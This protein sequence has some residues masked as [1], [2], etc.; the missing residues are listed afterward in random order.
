[1][2][3]ALP[4][5]SIYEKVLRFIQLPDPSAF[6]PL[7]IEVFRYQFENVPPYRTYCLDRGMDPGTVRTV[8]QIPAVSTV[9]FKYARME[10]VIEPP[11]G[12]SRLFLTSGTTIG[13]D[14]RGRH[15]VPFPEIYRASAIR[16]LN[17]MLFPDA[18]RTAMLALHPTADRMPESSLSQ[19]I[20]WC[21][22]EFGSGAAMCAATPSS[23]DTAAAIEFLRERAAADT[24]V[25]ILGTTASI[26]AL[27]RA[28]AA[29]GLAIELPAASRLMDTGGPKGQK[30]PLG[31]AEVAELAQRKLGLAPAMVINEYGMTEMCSQLYDATSFNSAH[32]GAAGSRVKLAPPWLR[33][34]ALDPVTLSPVFSGEIGLLGFF[35]LANVGSVSA[36]ITED[37]GVVS[38]DG[39]A[40]VG[41]AAGDSRGCA[42]AIEEFAARERTG[43]GQRPAA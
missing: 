3:Q 38:G 33:A 22:E 2:A 40:I 34:V 8:A 32:N 36:L 10:S 39:V 12:T 27:F 17:K 29:D 37:F 13:A 6:D 42:L 15:R 20:S 16:H 25:S 31:A 30:V 23:I 43:A 5:T 19:M 4:V 21:L 41:R 11:S 1:V 28:M 7:A 24:A 18:L 26:A 14:E 9:A 35:D